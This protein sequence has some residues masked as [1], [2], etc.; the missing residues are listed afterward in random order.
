M[1]SIIGHIQW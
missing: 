1:K